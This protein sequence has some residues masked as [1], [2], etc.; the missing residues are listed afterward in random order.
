[1]L[2]EDRNTKNL[3]R[4][5][6]EEELRRKDGGEELIY[7]PERGKEKITGFYHDGRRKTT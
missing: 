1:M 4:A 3:R 5:R 7:L 6:K 2:S